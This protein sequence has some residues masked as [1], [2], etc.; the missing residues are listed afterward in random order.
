MAPAFG[1]ERGHS[2]P[3]GFKG[4]TRQEA[5]VTANVFWYAVKRC[6][7]QAGIANL[8]PPTF[9]APVPDSAM[10]YRRTRTD[11]VSAWTR[12][13]PNNGAI[14]RK[15]TEASRCGYDRFGISV[16]SDTA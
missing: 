16:A 8:A 15:Q 6:A 3:K 1:G 4:G 13:C 14:H 12:F 7:H 10:M 5:G 2:I 11:S 9:V